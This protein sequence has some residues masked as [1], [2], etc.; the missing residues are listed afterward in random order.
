[1]YVHIYICICVCICVFNRTY[2][3]THPQAHGHTSA[4]ARTKHANTHTIARQSTQTPTH[5]PRASGDKAA[6]NPRGTMIK[7]GTNPRR[8][9]CL[10]FSTTKDM[11]GRE[12]SIATLL[13]VAFV[14]VQP[15]CLGAAHINRPAGQQRTCFLASPHHAYLA[16]HT[17]GSEAPRWRSERVPR[18]KARVALRAGLGDAVRNMWPFKKNEEDQYKDRTDVW[19]SLLVMN[20]V[21][22]GEL[23]VRTQSA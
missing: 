21:T 10:H 15:A 19:N 9:T 5:T 16:G 7:V 14:W 18:T 1:M 3:P 2:T 22:G 12:P 8:V 13:L 20:K 23:E 11:V 6:V 17:R 4:R